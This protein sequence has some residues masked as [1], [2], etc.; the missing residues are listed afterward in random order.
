[1]VRQTAENQ[2]IAEGD[3]PR[4]GTIHQTAYTAKV[5]EDYERTAETIREMLAPYDLEDTTELRVANIILDIAP[6][7][8]HLLEEV[9]QPVRKWEFAD[10]I[11]YLRRSGAYQEAIEIEQ[12]EFGGMP[13]PAPAYSNFDALR[14]QADAQGLE[15]HSVEGSRHFQTVDEAAEYFHSEMQAKFGRAPSI[16]LLRTALAAQPDGVAFA[17]LADG[18]FRPLQPGDMLHGDPVKASIDTAAFSDVSGDRDDWCSDPACV[19]CAVGKALEAAKAESAESYQQALR[20]FIDC[21][22]ALMPQ[23]IAGALTEK[24]IQ[25]LTPEEQL[26]ANRIK[27]RFDAAKAKS[28]TAERFRFTGGARDIIQ[29]TLDAASVADRASVPYCNCEK[30]KV[31]RG[32]FADASQAGDDS[33]LRGFDDPRS[34]EDSKPNVGD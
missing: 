3:G 7:L 2:Y 31:A 6:P 26:R 12:R 18:T 32:E 34:G 25:L 1:M 16:E 8:A 14:K 4:A 11:G 10:Y 5:A 29:Q 13:T 28:G 19:A 15:T 9:F 20:S 17:M 22:K 21:A 23:V 30:C 24:N 33:G 27:A